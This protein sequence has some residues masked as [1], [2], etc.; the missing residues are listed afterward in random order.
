M[1]ARHRL[2]R[3][4]LTAALL[5]APVAAVAHDSW[6]APR[7]GGSPDLLTLELGTGERFPARDSGTPAA[8]VARSGCRAGDGDRRPRQLVPH[9]AEPAFLEL[10]ARLEPASGV[11]CWA[12]LKPQPVTLSEELVARYFSEIRPAPELARRRAA[13]RAA[14]VPWRESYRKFMRV[15]LAPASAS[16]PAAGVL[17]ALRAPEGLGLEIVPLGDARLRAGEPLSFQLLREG[18]PVAGH[19][20]EWVSERSPLGVWRQ[21]D[22]QGRLSIT[23]PFGGRWL[24]RSVLLEAPADDEAPW[25]SRFATLLVQLP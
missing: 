13:Q 5:G 3:V 4:L 19:W 23:L 6:L 2:G 1:T 9:R 12:A 15:E 7:A 25:Q 11:A 21:T 24:L 16:E 20:V 17:A 10:R 14:G 18:Q 22:P 8:S